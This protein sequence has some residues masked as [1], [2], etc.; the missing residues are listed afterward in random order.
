MLQSV[1]GSDAVEWIQ[2][3]QPV[4]QVKRAVGNIIAASSTL[5]SLT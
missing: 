5:S 4:Q 1:I 3:E 2:V